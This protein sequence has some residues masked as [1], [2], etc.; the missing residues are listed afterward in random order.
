MP[1]IIND[2]E[3]T[4]EPPQPKS[5]TAP[6]PPAP[7]P[8]PPTPEQIVAITEWDRARRARLRAT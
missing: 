7:G 5:E 4:V 3:I 6:A 1:V 8:F 2:F